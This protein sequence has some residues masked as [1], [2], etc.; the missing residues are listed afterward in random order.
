MFELGDS[1]SIT[2]LRRVAKME[3]DGHGMCASID[4]VETE[5]DRARSGRFEE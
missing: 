1:A 5:H 3:F 2:K 4:V